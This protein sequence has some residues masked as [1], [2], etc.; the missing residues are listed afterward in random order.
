MTMPTSIMQGLGLGAGYAA[1]AAVMGKMLRNPD[2]YQEFVKTYFVGKQRPAAKSE[3]V[4]WARATMK[5]AAAAW[6]AQKA[7]TK[8]N[9]KRR[10]PR[11]ARQ[12]RVNPS[13][14]GAVYFSA[15]E[16][17]AMLREQAAYLENPEGAE[18]NLFGLG[19]KK[20]RRY[21]K[22]RPVYEPRSEPWSRIVS[23]RLAGWVT[24][25]LKPKPV[26][27]EKIAPGTHNP[28]KKGSGSYVVKGP[29]GQVLAKAGSYEDA[30]KK[31]QQW[32]EDIGGKVQ[33]AYRGSNPLCPS[34]MNPVKVGR[35]DARVRCPHCGKESKVR[36][37]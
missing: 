32:A 18:S 5:A 2:S 11:Q 19:K 7:G 21:P 25:P 36:G 6:K 26:A 35:H 37:G 16:V 30:A 34:C 13:L 15:D 17:E 20:R 29:S 10:A 14:M 9:P 31:A 28:S 8:A 22:R 27:W 12:L 3:R 1:S 4:A 23:S 33:I 24:S